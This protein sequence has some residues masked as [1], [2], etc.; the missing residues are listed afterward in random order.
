MGGVSKAM[1]NVDVNR[2]TVQDSIVMFP[3]IVDVHLAIYTDSKGIWMIDST[4]ED[5]YKVLQDIG[6]SLSVLPSVVP[7]EYFDTYS[8]FPAPC[9]IPQY[10]SSYKYTTKIM[11]S[12]YN[13]NNDKKS[14]VTPLRN[15]W[16]R[17]LPKTIQKSTQPQNTT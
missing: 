15:A 2:K 8:A 12:I 10:C 6:T 7:D 16:N 14:Y 17:G 3:F 9:V 4:A 13:M 11:S 5:L 1:L